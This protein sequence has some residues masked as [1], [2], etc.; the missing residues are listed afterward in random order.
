MF[1]GIVHG[2]D[3]LAFAEPVVAFP[4]LRMRISLVAGRRIDIYWRLSTRRLFRV[5]GVT[6]ATP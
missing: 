3:L 5:G 6:I 1:A 2:R 4:S